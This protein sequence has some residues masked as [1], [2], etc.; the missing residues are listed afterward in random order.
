MLTPPIPS[1]PL[2]LYIVVEGESTVFFLAQD[3]NRWNGKSNILH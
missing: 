3:V 1:K 2:K